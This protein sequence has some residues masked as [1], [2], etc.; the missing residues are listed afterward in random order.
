MGMDEVMIGAIIQAVCACAGSESH[1]KQL[2]LQ[3]VSLGK[4]RCMCTSA[5]VFPTH[6]FAYLRFAYGVVSM[7]WRI[8]CVALYVH[9]CCQL[10][11]FS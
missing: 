11:Y 2:R 7:A 10:A 4:S 9:Y 8:P 5:W 1:A 3:R 6:T